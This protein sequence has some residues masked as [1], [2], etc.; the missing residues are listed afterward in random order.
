LIS[1][2]KL[3][4]GVSSC[5]F[6]DLTWLSVALQDL[7]K[8]GRLRAKAQALL[9]AAC[10]KARQPPPD[11]WLV[12]STARLAGAGSGGGSGKGKKRK[13]THGVSRVSTH[14]AGAAAAAAAAAGTSEAAQAAAATPAPANLATLTDA[15]EAGTEQQQQSGQGPMDAAVPSSAPGE[16]SGDLGAEEPAG[17]GTGS[18]AKRAR[19]S[20]LKHDPSASMLKQAL[21]RQAVQQAQLQLQQDSAAVS[22]ADADRSAASSPAVSRESSPAAPAASNG[23][24]ASPGADDVTESGT[25]RFSVRP[26]EVVWVQVKPNPPWPALVI[27]SEEASDFS[28]KLTAQRSTQVSQQQLHRAPGKLG[29]CVGVAGGNMHTVLV[30]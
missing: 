30:A 23:Q 24:D 20:G 14:A 8:P 2:V 22:P 28:V 11:V 6:V 1:S 10:I 13:S 21:H 12:K 9:G 7:A 25:V 27:S 15:A 16:C 19:L 4:V 18:T 3:L 17:A 26:G 29:T 5:A